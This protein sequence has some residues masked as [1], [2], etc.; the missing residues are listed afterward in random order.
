MRRP[1]VK[2]LNHQRVLLEHSLDDSPLH[3]YA[4]SV[5]E[6]DFGKSR[7]VRFV[8]VLFDHGGDVSRGESMEVEGSVDGKPERRP[9]R[10]EGL[11]LHCYG[12][13]EDLS[14]RTVTSVLM[15]PRTE[16]SPTTVMRRGW[17]A[18]TRS[19]RI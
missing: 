8:Q 4:A 13:V 17:Q 10:V 18:A 6:S 9:S 7:R 19:S 3:T 14:Y 16:K 11:I 15:P 5:N 2:K 12:V 1:V